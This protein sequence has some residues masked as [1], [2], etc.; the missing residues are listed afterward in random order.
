ML[1]RLVPFLL[2]LGV[3]CS[4]PAPEAPEPPPP[5][6][7]VQV[8]LEPAPAEI[9]VEEEVDLA[10]LMGGGPE[11][12]P[13]PAPKKAARKKSTDAGLG[14]EGGRTLS[15]SQIKAVV[16]RNAP[17]V[18]ACYERQLKQSPGLRGRVKIGWTIGADGRVRSPSV[19]SNSTR[20]RTMLPCITKAVRSWKF[21]RAE[22]PAD[23][24]W[25]FVF[26]PQGGF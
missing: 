24:E 19:V 2:A 3:A 21:P 17:Q 23:V 25:P 20:N 1:R 12:T 5:T 14:V 7:A 26:K 16:R 10:G 6:P 13:T 8:E 9:Q 4:E 22:S 18:R 11:A 15:A